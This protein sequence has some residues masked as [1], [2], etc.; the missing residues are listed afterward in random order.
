MSA[1][2]HSCVFEY[3]L[4]SFTMVKTESTKRH[5]AKANWH[6][7][8]REGLAFGLSLDDPCELCGCLTE[9]FGSTWHTSGG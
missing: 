1:H 7:H 8:V 9:R 6:V 5:L 3:N 4:F 2:L